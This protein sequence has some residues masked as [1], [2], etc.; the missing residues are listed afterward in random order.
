MKCMVIGLGNFGSALA[1]ELV[2]MKVEVV[3]VDKSKHRV[4]AMKDILNEVY[5]TDLTERS[6]VYSLPIP[7]MDAIVVSI[8]ENFGDSIVITTQILEII[9]RKPIRLYC[10]ALSDVHQKI[11]SNM[12]I[13][14]IFSPEISYS[15]DLSYVIALNNVISAYS[16]SEKYILCE[17]MLPSSYVGLKLKDIPFK[18]YQLQPLLVKKILNDD[19]D[20][21]PILMRNFPCQE[22]LPEEMENELIT[23]EHVVVIMGTLKSLQSFLS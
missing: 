11:L 20:R 4:D 2:S 9:K 5:I 10:R 21:Q 22:F 17:I 7:D 18:K 16:I 19:Y 23:A 8:G 14:N 12:G 3:G 6:A 13:Q 15:R 1:R